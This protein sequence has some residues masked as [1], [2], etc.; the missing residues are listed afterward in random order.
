MKPSQ[1]L[2]STSAYRREAL[3][4]GNIH[5]TE[6]YE[7]TGKLSSKKGVIWPPTLNF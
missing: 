2:F 4:V 1:Y 7:L 5:L 6:V 3:H